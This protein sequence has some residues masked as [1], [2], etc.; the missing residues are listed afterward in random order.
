M[1]VPQSLV[2][3]GSNVLHSDSELR[4]LATIDPERARAELERLL[5]GRA[6]VSVFWDG[7]PGG[8]VRSLHRK[9]I[10]VDYSG[11]GEA[12][13]RLVAWL[14]HQ[15]PRKTTVVTDDSALRRRCQQLGARIVPARGFVDQLRTTRD[16]APDRPPPS[17][18]DVDFWMREF[19]CKDGE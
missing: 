14:K 19:Q 3:D 11:D 12:D 6:R 13:D 8:S 17:P 15:G 1:G 16:V 18:T 4:R 2:I 5:A 9:G 10:R 7:G